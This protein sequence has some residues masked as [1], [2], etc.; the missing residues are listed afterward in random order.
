M[1]GVDRDTW[2]YVSNWVCDS[3]FVQHQTPE[4]NKYIQA[5]YTDNVR[6]RYTPVG[7]P[8]Y[9]HIP[10]KTHVDIQ[11][12]HT[13]FV[14]RVSLKQE[15]T[16][17]GLDS[18]YQKPLSVMLCVRHTALIP[19]VL[20]YDFTQT[21][22]GPTKQAAAKAPSNFSI[23]VEIHP[24]YAQCPTVT[25]SRLCRFLLEH[26]RE[27]VVDTE[28]VPLELESVRAHGIGVDQF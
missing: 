16:L 10:R 3:S 15:I 12:A 2:L 11:L 7:P 6:G 13:P 5:L 28:K 19:Q 25:A 9:T 26:M 20:Q 23:E 17:S 18:P 24:Q 27:L 22:T 4:G 21:A 14:I 8:V 1:D